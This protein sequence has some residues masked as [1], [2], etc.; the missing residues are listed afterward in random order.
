MKKLINDILT[1]I[2]GKTYDA[3]RVAMW[4]GIL[5]MIAL[6]GY[7]IYKGLPVDFMAFG[8]G[9]A[10]IIAGTGFAIGTKKETEPK[11]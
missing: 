6:A 7:N 4:P 10:S 1:G 2:D 11:P 3:A 9:F 5:G 8:T